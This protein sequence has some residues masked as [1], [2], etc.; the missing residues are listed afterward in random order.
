MNGRIAAILATF[1]VCIWLS[2]L[3]FLLL[4]ANAPVSTS[5]LPFEKLGQFGD[6]FGVLAS[7]M[8]T[9][10]L[11]GA[12]Y[13]I[14]LQNKNYDRQQFESNFYTILNSVKEK[15]KE[16][17]LTIIERIPIAE[18]LSEKA[19]YKKLIKSL[20]K[21]KHE[22]KGPQAFRVILYRIRN[23]IGF[24]GYADPKTVAIKYRKIISGNILLKNYF[25]ILYHLYAMLENS[26]VENKEI[27]SRIIRAHLSDPEVCLI[28]YNCS[29]GDGR[30]KFKKLV[31]IYS[32]LHNMKNDYLD[33]YEKAELRFFRRKISNDAFRFDNIAPVTY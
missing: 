27:Y 5:S 29:V 3:L 20:R 33:P 12:L 17:H 7:L 6:S 22:F 19:E 21:T 30:F 11:V 31:E 15:Q 32:T 23:E 9:L 26:S 8:S 1:V 2:W 10:A 18:N 13:S 16:I 4:G 14:H 24:D 28:A 25:R